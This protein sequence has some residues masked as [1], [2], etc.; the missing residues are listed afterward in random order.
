MSAIAEDHVNEVAR[1]LGHVGVAAGGHHCSIVRHSSDVAFQV[2]FTRKGKKGRI[3]TVWTF[4]GPTE[5]A[6]IN[7]RRGD[8]CQAAL[9]AAGPPEPLHRRDTT[10][11]S[12][13]GFSFDVPAAPD[14]EFYDKVAERA[15]WARD[16]V[17]VYD[18]DVV[19]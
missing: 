4:D 7:K 11:Y 9:A 6:A 19:D 5:R 18:L 10:V 12:Y 2:V 1:R 14:A 17:I 8:A 3:E 16:H 13:V 15:A